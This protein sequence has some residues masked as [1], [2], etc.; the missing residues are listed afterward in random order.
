[1]AR[2]DW[3]RIRTLFE[4]ALDL[5]DSA[6]AAFLDQ[7][8]A[9]DPGLRVEVEAMLAAD[10]R[11][12]QEA[13]NVCDAA[14][15]LMAVLKSSERHSDQNALAGLRLGPWRLRQEIGRGGMGAVYL[16][17]RDD[18]EYVQQA[19]IKL[20]RPGWDVAEL[21]QRFRA[22]RQILATLNHPNIARLL[23]GGVSVDGKPYLVMEYVKGDEIGR[24]CD[25]HRLDIEARLRLFLTV[26]EAVAH[27]HQRLVVHR[28]L[29][30][31]NILIDQ[32]GQVKLLD[33]G[34]AKLIEPD[35]SITA[36]TSRVFTPEYAAPEQVRGE[37][38]TTSVDIYSLG[39][40]LFDLLTGRRPYGATGSTPAA[41]E[42]AILTEEPERPSVAAMAQDE[43]K[44][45]PPE[46]RAAA[47]GIG[48]Q[49][50]SARLRGDLDAIVLKALRKEPEQRYASVMAFAEDVQR[51]LQQQPVLARRGNL[52]YRVTRF[53]QRHA[54]ASALVL[55]A[56][57]S[58]FV[59]MALAL[60]QAE[61]ARAEASK[62]RAALAF[63]TG[64]FTLADPVAAQGSK[65][66]ARELLATGSQRIRE[67]LLDQPEA[68]AELL[69]A[70][71]DAY[72]G[73]GLYDDAL[74]ILDEAAQ[75]AEHPGPARLSHAIVL[76][77]LG[78]YDDALVALQAL[79]DS[80]SQ[81]RDADLD[82]LAQIDLRRAVT[83]VSMNRLD[84]AGAVYER[85][86]NGQ[87]ARHGDQDRRTQESVLRY[88]SWLVL[89]GRSQDAYPLT[90]AV[91]DHVRLQ[92]PRDNDFF[93]RALGAHA[94]VVSNTGPYREAEALR[95][96]E[97]D[98]TVAI[99]GDA[100]A[101]TQSSRS[102]LATVLFA[103]Q[104]YEEAL[105]LFEGVLKARREQFEPDHPLRSLA[106]NH[107]AA[108]LVA[109]HREAEAR[110]YAEEA[111]ALRLKNFGEHH[112]NTAMSLRT[113]GKVE[114]AAGN[115]DKAEALFLRAIASF[116]AALGPNSN[117]LLG[118]LNDL[119]RLRL[120]RGKPE[121]DCAAAQRSFDISESAGQPEVPE[122]QYQF[123]LLGAC[124]AANGDPAGLEMLRTAV[125]RM[126][127]E[128]G[129]DDDRSIV[130][131]KLLK[132]AEARKPATL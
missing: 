57:A 111:L 6:R 68:R 79:R 77:Q 23:D 1:M 108:T 99:Y 84:E 30:P 70:M 74:P 103:E 56:A 122:A 9:D 96:E 87:R 49:Q 32:S 18:G 27:A 14:P 83:L 128:L 106:T 31:S 123:A 131:G 98:L 34:I 86:L 114:F 60:W 24:Y 104:R 42:H 48:A 121:P 116:E 100:H 52:R 126:Q 110:P 112:R 29:K 54:L 28:D 115:L 92:H 38:V 19:A 107:V 81:R 132:E 117:T 71:G 95:R 2:P 20:V 64:L 44:T 125:Q 76:H 26:C 82:L 101:Y 21:L 118:S 47:R 120:A 65:V 39:L 67:Q 129:P 61:Q 16:A 33:F 93:A 127:V 40:L 45:A 94:M 75:I 8:C 12:S 63:M 78:R 46:H 90:K 51:H 109:L 69:R 15:E 80:E 53:L 17:E 7:A 59:G 43:T 66:T 113:L 91:V 5:T 62:S 11:A 72:R 37:I 88:A 25:Q 35:A 36:S 50:L 3:A 55:L 85:L 124:K 13:T 119:A 4:Q 22:E 97:Y 130:A 58:L 73:L 105:V 41:Y 89:R 10:A 102:N